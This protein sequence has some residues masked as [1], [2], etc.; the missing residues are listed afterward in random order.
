[1][2]LTKPAQE[3]RRA[4]LLVEMAK[5]GEMH[6]REDWLRACAGGWQSHATGSC[7][8]LIERVAHGDGSERAY[9]YRRFSAPARKPLSR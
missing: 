9:T 1:M 4:E 3:L 8:D 2:L 7:R 5:I 6:E